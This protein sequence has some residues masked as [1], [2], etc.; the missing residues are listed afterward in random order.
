M[1]ENNKQEDIKQQVNKLEDSIK[2]QV[3]E[4]KEIQ[5]ACKHPNESIKIKDA[6]PT[7]ASD[8]RKCCDLCGHVL[9]YP[10]KEELDEWCGIK[11]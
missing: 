2:E 3:K 7:G 1:N 4:L 5:N 6:N 10:S 8:I 11:K 9:G